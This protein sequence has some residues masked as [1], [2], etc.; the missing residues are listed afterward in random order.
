MAYNIYNSDGVI[1]LT[2]SEGEVDDFSTSLNLVGKNVNNYGQYVNNNLVYLLTNFAAAEGNSPRS[3]QEGQLWY[4]KTSKR[5]NV[6]DGSEFNPFYGS[7]V[8]D[9]ELTTTS[10][11]DLW[12]DL[13]N[14]Q[15]KVWTGT[16]YQLVGPAVPAQKG[17]FGIEP[18]ANTS[19]IR[20]DDSE[21]PVDVGIMYSFGNAIGCLTTVSFT[22]NTASSIAFLGTDTAAPIVDGLTV[23]NDLDVKGDLY[24]QGTTYTQEKTLTTTYNITPYGDFQSVSTGTNQSRINSGNIAIRNDL[25]KLFPTETIATLTQVAFVLGSEVRVLCTYNTQTSVRR[26]ILNDTLGYSDWEPYNLYYNPFTAAYNN[27]IP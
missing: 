19:T 15:L 27:I 23:F 5:L 26:F 20:V 14:S 24:I 2:L 25:R 10:T 17:R 7:Y 4:N 21:I 6:Y 8:S 22:M 3:P 11:G 1:L 13:S 18:P 9:T 12:F 16:N